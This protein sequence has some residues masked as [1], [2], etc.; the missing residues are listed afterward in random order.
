MET[1][2]ED[3]GTSVVRIVPRGTGDG[4]GAEMIMMA[5]APPKDGITVTRTVEALIEG[6]VFFQQNITFCVQKIKK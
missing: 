2:R 1:T 3:V 6:T 4:T 5:G